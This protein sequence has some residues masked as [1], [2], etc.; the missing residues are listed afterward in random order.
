M[1]R[2]QGLDWFFSG[3]CVGVARLH[4]LQ[5]PNGEYLPAEFYWE[6]LGDAPSRGGP[7]YGV[8]SL[9]TGRGRFYVGSSE[10]VLGRIAHHRS[11]LRLGR[12]K[13]KALLSSFECSTKTVVRWV[14]LDS[15]E[16]VRHV[17]Q[18][19]L[20]IAFGKGLLFNRQ[21]TSTSPLGMRHTDEVRKIM[22][23]KAVGRTPSKE[24]KLKLSN[25]LSGRQLDEPHRRKLVD[26][27]IS[28]WADKAFRERWGEKAKRAVVIEGVEY[29]S[30]SAAA[31]AYG[32]TASRV[33]AR[34]VSDNPRFKEWRYMNEISTRKKKTTL[35]RI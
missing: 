21:P 8:Y 26:S 5:L 9:D 23:E 15:L 6:R 11:H 35:A 20:D 22:S 25:A 30:L 10:N 1:D 12:H 18:V 24:T 17:E 3:S 14:V 19:L 4:Y 31:Q 7:F 13:N 2:S 16:M 34:V 27:N 32:V 33:R 29:D 28:R